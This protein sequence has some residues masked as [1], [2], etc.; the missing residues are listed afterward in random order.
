VAE[1]ERDGAAIWVARLD[2]RGWTEHVARAIGATYC[3][4]DT[5]ADY[6]RFTEPSGD[7]R[8]TACQKCGRRFD[9]S[10]EAV[11]RDRR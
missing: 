8:V 7:G 11:Q 3:G 6:V 1:V 9:A 10:V 5:P 4:R 2:G